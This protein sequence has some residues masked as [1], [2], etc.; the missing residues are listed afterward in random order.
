MLFP[1]SDSE[2]QKA[3]RPD[4]KTDDYDN[5]EGS[6][7]HSFPLFKYIKSWNRGPLSNIVFWN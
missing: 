5:C 2:E 6:F 3:E 1:S 7:G 4:C